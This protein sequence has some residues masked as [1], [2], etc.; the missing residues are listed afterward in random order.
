MAHVS[1]RRLVSP[2]L[3]PFDPCRPRASTR[4]SS[5]SRGSLVWPTCRVRRM[6][7]TCCMWT[8]NNKRHSGGCATRVECVV[9]LARTLPEMP[10]RPLCVSRTIGRQSL[11]G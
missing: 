4:P 5:G 6:A 7:Q 3:L 11:R 1:S 10:N 2:H 9:A 8:V